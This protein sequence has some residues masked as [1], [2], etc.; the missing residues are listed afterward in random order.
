[1]TCSITVNDGTTTVNLENV[2]EL[3]FD[4][5][6]VNGGGGIVRFLNGSAIKQQSW[7]KEQFTITGRDKVPHGLRD[8]DFSQVLTVTVTTGLGTGVYTCLSLGV[9]ENWALKQANVTWSMV[10]EEN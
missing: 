5:A 8:L 2:P 4:H 6:P 3:G 7:Y 1:M 10:L 9:S